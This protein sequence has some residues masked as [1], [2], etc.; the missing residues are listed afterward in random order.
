MYE[1]KTSKGVC[2][3]ASSNFYFLHLSVLPHWSD[4]KYHEQI[5]IEEDAT[6][7]S[8]QV[9]F[10]PYMSSLLTEV[11]VQDPYI[12]HTH[13]VRNL[14]VPHCFIEMLFYLLINSLSISHAIIFLFKVPLPLYK[15]VIQF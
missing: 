13:Q 4:G 12:R 8:Y 6:G 3:C 5:R 9:L 10:K 14:S 11:W 2:V 15:W 1:C 7:Y